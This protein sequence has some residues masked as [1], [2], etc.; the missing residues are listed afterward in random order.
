M[1]L[2]TELMVG[3]QEKP[4]RLQFTYIFATTVVLLV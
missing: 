4:E 3:L 2:G 1:T